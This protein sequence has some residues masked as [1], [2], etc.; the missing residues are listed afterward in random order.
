[1]NRQQRRAKHKVKAPHVPKPTLQPLTIHYGFALPL[2]AVVITYGN[3]FQ[4]ALKP[5]EVD[6]MIGALTTVKRQL[7]EAQA[8]N[9]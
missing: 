3:Q 4:C 5:E 9:V 8:V 2:G 1:M 7:L 6:T